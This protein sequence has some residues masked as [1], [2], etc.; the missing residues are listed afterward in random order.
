[1]GN[2]RHRRTDSF[3]PSTHKPGVSVQS[4]TGS[5]MYRLSFVSITLLTLTACG[6][7][8]A[9]PDASNTDAATSTDVTTNPSSSNR[10]DT[11][12]STIKPSSP[13]REGPWGCY[14][15]TNRAC[16]CDIESEAACDH[17]EGYWTQGCT[18]CALDV[19][20]TA[21]KPT[22]G[23][24]TDGG[25]TDADVPFSANDS[26]ANA[27]AGCYDPAS[28]SCDCATTEAACD[29]AEGFWTANCA[30]TPPQDADTSTFEPSS[31]SSP[32][33][34]TDTT[35][36]SAFDAADAG[37]WGCYLPTQH[38]CDCEITDS[39]RCGTVQGVWTDGCDSCFASTAGQ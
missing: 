27:E 24:A 17:A 39:A 26:G 3:R 37:M 35:R 11:S 2:G 7:D 14:F 23:G 28:H 15:S 36:G 5:I 1:M 13:N 19:P 10:E 25:A 32:E 20:T 16:D 34:D 30:C 18:S 21:P 6:D 8:V 29:D 31:S 12:T 9:P 4:T 22:D 33:R 38:R